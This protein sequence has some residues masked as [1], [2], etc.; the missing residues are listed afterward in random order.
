M[1]VGELLGAGLFRKLG[2]ERVVKEAENGGGNLRIF[3]ERRCDI[4]LRIGDAGLA[5]ITRIGAQHVGL[6]RRE[7]GRQ[8]QPVEA[9]IIDRAGEGGDEAS[10][11][12]AP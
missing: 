4:I 10:S 12:V 8:D 7:P 5:E 9:V 11:R 1:Q 3:I 6:A 2:V